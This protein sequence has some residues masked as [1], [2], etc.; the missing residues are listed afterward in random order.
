MDYEEAFDE[1]R[2]KVYM[3]Y[4]DNVAFGLDLTAEDVLEDIMI[5]VNKLES[6]ITSEP[7]EVEE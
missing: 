3:L 1:I 6:K 7:P 4:R 2:L 5:Y